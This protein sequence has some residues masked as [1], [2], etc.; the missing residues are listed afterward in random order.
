MA[1]KEA[2]TVGW[3]SLLL[4]YETHRDKVNCDS[5]K[6]SPVALQKE[7]EIIKSLVC[8]GEFL[9]ISCGAQESM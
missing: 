8:T 9:K 4:A 7:N 6:I 5:E 2:V 1:S 3:S